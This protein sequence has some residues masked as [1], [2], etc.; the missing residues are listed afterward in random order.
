MR[1]SCFHS[2]VTDGP[3]DQ[4]TD[5]QSLISFKQKD[6]GALRSEIDT[7]NRDQE[8]TPRLEAMESLLFPNLHNAV[9]PQLRLWNFY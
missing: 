5:E 2:C 4:R 7:R 8:G 9:S 1:T 6:S 3:M